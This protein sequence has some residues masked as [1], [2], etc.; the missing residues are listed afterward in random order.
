MKVRTN[1]KKVTFPVMLCSFVQAGRFSR[2]F[3]AEAQTGGV[4]GATGKFVNKYLFKY[5][6]A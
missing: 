2:H 6:I 3:G 1:G 4:A 5:F